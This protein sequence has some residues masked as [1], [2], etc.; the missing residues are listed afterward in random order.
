MKLWNVLSVAALG[1]LF[2]VGCS[3]TT[4]TT[5]DGGTTSDTGTVKDTGST[6]DTGSVTDS[7]GT[8]DT[9]GAVTCEQCQKDAQNKDT[10]ACKDQV[11]A[12]STSTDVAKGCNDLFSCVSACT[13]VACQNACIS[14]STS[15][16]GKALLNCVIT[17]CFDTGKP[18]AG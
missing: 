6:T 15:D 3:S 10:G 1:T 8:T 14:A 7:G 4:T 2:V 5:T 12:C 17:Q 13:D 11:A 18:C 9:G 16:P